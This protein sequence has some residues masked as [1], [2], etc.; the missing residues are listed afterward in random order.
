M[1]CPC[2]A[3]KSGLSGDVS[4]VSNREPPIM[5]QSPGIQVVNQSQEYGYGTGNCFTANYMFP[6]VVAGLG[7]LLAYSI[8]NTKNKPT[9]KKRRKSKARVTEY[10]VRFI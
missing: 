8:I 5:V 3:N 2:E 1:S 7:T 4:V 10:D 9:S 6:L